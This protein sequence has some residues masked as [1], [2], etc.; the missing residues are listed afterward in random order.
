[1]VTLVCSGRSFTLGQVIVGSSRTKV[2]HDALSPGKYELTVSNENWCF[3][4]KPLSVLTV[5]VEIPV[6]EN[7][8]TAMVTIEQ[9]AF[10]MRIKTDYTTD[11]NVFFEENFIEETVVSGS[12]KFCVP[13]PGIYKIQPKGCHVF[14]KAEY[15]FN[16]NNPTL[17]ELTAK[18][19]E[20]VE[21]GNSKILKLQ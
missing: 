3:T 21:K 2:T 13:S 9:K 5:P 11:I 6:D 10:L 14:E 18:F 4:D 20:Q 7:I 12:N 19:H 8:D 1:M 15:E 17:I 16:S